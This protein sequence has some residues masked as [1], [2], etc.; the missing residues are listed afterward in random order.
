MVTFI[1]SFIL[2]FFQQGN[3]VVYGNSCTTDPGIQP[4][5]IGVFSDVRIG[6]DAFLTYSNVPAINSYTE[7]T[8]LIGHRAEIQTPT[9]CLMYLNP[10]V[11]L[12]HY[13]RLRGVTT[14]YILPTIPN[15]PALVGMQYSIQ[16]I[17]PI[18]WYSHW[19]I[20]MTNGVE[21]QVMP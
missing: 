13:I 15:D 12:T 14:I 10:C 1:L 4:P 8:V 7:A 11:I 9:G 17:L 21:V 19:V 16:S 5:T 2:C 3:N 6:R 20:Q 18:Q